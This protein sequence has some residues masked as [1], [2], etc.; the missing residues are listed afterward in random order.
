M[1]RTVS[2]A[3]RAA[4]LFFPDI[5]FAEEPLQGLLEFVHV[6]GARADR[7]DVLAV[8]ADDVGAD[9]ARAGVFAQIPVELVDFLDGGDP[10]A[11]RR[12]SGPSGGRGP[13]P[14]GASV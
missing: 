13:R 4:A 5:P 8:A 3:C 7:D 14:I 9:L 12:A 6:V 1:S 2:T 11:Q 10:D